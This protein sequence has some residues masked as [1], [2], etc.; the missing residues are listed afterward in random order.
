M[1]PRRK[2]R[3]ILV[4]LMLGG[5]GTAVALGLSAF[6]DNIMLF[7]S[8]TDIAAGGVESGRR[9]RVG[10][11]VVDGSVIR[12]AEDLNVRFALSDTAQSVPVV[13]RG[14]LP[15]LFREGQGI[16]AMGAL[17]DQGVFVATEVLA[18][19]DENYMPPEVADALAKANGKP[20]TTDDFGE[21]TVVE[22]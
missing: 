10:G 13:Y 4:C 22:P 5:V 7:H 14:I 6:R 3:L 1:T 9:F 21:N 15:D 12:G 20:A 17:D 16:V 8:P 18:K 19:H 2:Q 11:M